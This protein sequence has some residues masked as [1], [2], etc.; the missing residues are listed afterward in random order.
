M[1]NILKHFLFSFYL[2]PFGQSSGQ[3]QLKPASLKCHWVLRYFITSVFSFHGILLIFNST[4]SLYIP[5]SSML[6]RY[7]TGKLRFKQK[8]KEGQFVIDINTWELIQICF[9]NNISLI[10]CQCHVTNLAFFQ[11]YRFRELLLLHLNDCIIIYLIIVRLGGEKQD[12]C[13]KVWIWPI[14]GGVSAHFHHFFQSNNKIQVETDYWLR[15]YTNR[16]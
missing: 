5:T 15:F 2:L 16:L 8:G 14:Y 6:S 3:K 11:L 4:A 10:V 9:K 13:M 1:S 7:L 12:S